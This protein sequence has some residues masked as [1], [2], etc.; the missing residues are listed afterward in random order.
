MIGEEAEAVT[1]W[2]LSA[3]SGRNRV[4]GQVSVRPEPLDSPPASLYCF[5]RFQDLAA[6]LRSSCAWILGAMLLEPSPVF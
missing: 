5:P 1:Q 2:T 4:R 6:S 3:V